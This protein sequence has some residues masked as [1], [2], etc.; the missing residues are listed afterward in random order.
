MP[1][2]RGIAGEVAQPGEVRRT[3][4]RTDGSIEGTVVLIEKD[5]GGAKRW[6]TGEQASVE[7]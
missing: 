5:G 6:G 7:A 1:P 3:E 4:N 2:N